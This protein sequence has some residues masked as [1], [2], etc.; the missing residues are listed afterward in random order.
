M[1]ANSEKQLLA[2]LYD[3][4]FDAVT[5]APEGKASQWGKNN[6][7]FQMAKNYV[8]D[9]KDFEGMQSPSNPDGD[10]RPLAAFSSLVDQLPTPGALWSAN[11][12]RVSEVYRRLLP[13]ANAVTDPDP[14]Q[15]KR[16]E[17]AYKFLN[18]EVKVKSA[19]GEKTKIMPSDEVIACEEAQAAYITAVT[20]YR[21]AYNGYDL[22]KK[23]D[24]RA[25]NAVAP[26]LQLVLD[27]AWN[28]WGRAGREEV[29]EAQAILA[30]TINDAVRSV[31]QAAR[32]SV[33][34]QHLFAPMT[35]NGYQWLPAY[36]LPTS[37]ASTALKGSKFTLK[38]AYL[39]KTYSNFAQDYSAKVSGGWGL[40]HGSG[41]VSGGS[42]E[43]KEHM[44]AQNFTLEAELFF[45][46]IHRPWFSPLLLNM[47]QWNVTGTEVNGISNGNAQNPQGS[48][49]LVPT[50]FVIA[51]DV[52]ITADF[53]ESDKKDISNTISSK[54]E[55][56]WGPFSVS[57]GYSQT[58]SSGTFTS[59][60]NGST[61]TL[62]G[63]QLVAWMHALMPASPPLPGP[64]LKPKT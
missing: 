1:D 5:Y 23:E 37:W 56:G 17:Q 15:Y 48:M 18:T 64:G 12:L 6:T 52:K 25:W 9:P 42:T 24:Q 50:G 53:S 57:G 36:A 13:N 54:A 11:G 27:Q 49:P 2:T 21:T 47:K 35:A 58:S 19:T 61:L 33:S 41:E 31:I 43:K 32:D 62:P 55:V 30:S 10:L 38:S 29:E 3:R 4:L 22:T 45:V 44:D 7:Y 51:R 60:F 16:Y 34:D 46:S 39:N 26:G 20:G 40:W 59:K 8:L 63:L 14:A 28:R